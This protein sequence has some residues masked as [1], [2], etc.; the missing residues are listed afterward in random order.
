MTFQHQPVLLGQTIEIIAGCNP[1]RILDGTLGGAGHS[2]E[3][4]KR[5]PDAT[6]L[7]I[8][9]DQV[10]LQAAAQ[11]LQPYQDRIK[12][13]QATFSQMTQVANK[14]G[15]TSIDAILLDIGVSSPQIDTPERGFSFRQDG[16]LDMRMN[17][18]D[19][20]TAADILN[21]S[22]QEDLE[23]IIRDYGEERKARQI[24]RAIVKRRERSPWR[25]TLELAQ[26][27]EDVVGFKN[28][29]GLPPATRTFQAL[30]IAVNREL[31]ELEN[32]LP[33]AIRLLSPGGVIAVITFHSLEDRI[34]KQTFQHEAATC[35][36]PPKMPL[37]TCNKI[38]TLELITK[39]PI[40]ADEDEIRQNPRSSCAKLRAARRTDQPIDKKPDNQ[41]SIT[42]KTNH[43]RQQ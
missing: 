5:L 38:Q 30:R 36:C 9:R 23:T 34:V 1:A 33:S 14:I 8:D 29:H 19:A 22:T 10:A 27:V 26:L 17:K 25:N 4:L 20:V 16:P 31:E 40:T 3:L 32:A 43:G 35:V 2:S 37:C 13:V 42:N 12:L 15:W 7:G 41:E 21:T 6:L 39:K 11:K 24:A 18:N 28:Q